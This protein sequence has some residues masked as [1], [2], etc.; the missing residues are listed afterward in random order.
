MASKEKI[1]TLT[2]V[3]GPGDGDKI[4]EI[5]A[6]VMNSLRDNLKES[7]VPVQQLNVSLETARLLGTED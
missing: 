3:I 4:Q 1:G 5:L 6:S 2:I 7:G